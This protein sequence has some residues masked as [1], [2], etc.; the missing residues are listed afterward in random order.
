MV[1][2]VGGWIG[3]TI[4]LLNVYPSLFPWDTKPGRLAG[5]LI[6]SLAAAFALRVSYL[7]ADNRADITLVAIVVV[8]LAAI[9]FTAVAV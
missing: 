6:C 2:S 7:A 9:V 4:A 5:I 1:A 8:L 3:V